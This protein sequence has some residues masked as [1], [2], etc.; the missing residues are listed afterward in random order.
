MP[1]LRSRKEDWQIVIF[2]ERAL[3]LRGGLFQGHDFHI[4]ALFI[5]L[6]EQ[7]R[8]PFIFELIG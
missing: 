8:D 4:L 1:V 5:E 6:I 3:D 7:F 2:F